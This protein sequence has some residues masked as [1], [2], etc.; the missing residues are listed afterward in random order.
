MLRK[1][2]IASLLNC[3]VFTTSAVD[4]PQ[5]KALKER[6]STRNRTLVK[7]IE[8]VYP[9]QLLKQRISGSVTMAFT[10][11]TDGTVS[12]IKVIESEPKGVFDDASIKALSGW[13]YAPV[14]SEIREVLT[15][16]DFAPPQV[17]TL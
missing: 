7:H 13:R 10:I 11:E 16:F 3:V 12:H 6:I 17:S 1:Y 4:T 14:E 9:A 2:F 15:R 5:V 8:P